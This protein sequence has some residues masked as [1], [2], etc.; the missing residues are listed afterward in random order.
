MLYL[1]N[2]QC[3]LESREFQTLLSVQRYQDYQA[4]LPFQFL[5]EHLAFPFMSNKTSV[6]FRFNFD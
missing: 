4:Y 2:S 5:L 3:L 6:C 1:N